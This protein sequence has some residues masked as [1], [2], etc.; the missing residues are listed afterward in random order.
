MTA[1]AETLD[2]RERA[3]ER[4]KEQARRAYLDSVAA[5]TP[6]NGQQL[7][8]L[9]DR[10]DKWGWDRI[11]EACEQEEAGDQEPPRAQEPPEPEIRPEPVTAATPEPPAAAAPAPEPPAPVQARPAAPVR[12][13]GIGDPQV[14]VPEAAPR[15]ADPALPGRPAVSAT[16]QQKPEPVV[17]AR[18]A[19]SA[20]VQRTTV[21]AVAVVAVVA[22][23]VSYA[24]MQHLAAMAGEDWRSW[25]LPLAVDGLMV[26]ASMSMLVRRRQGRRAGVL[27]WCSL[28]AGIVASLAANV[29]AAEPT[30]IGRL[31]AAWPPLALLLA[32]EL[33]MQQVREARRA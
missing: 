30:L 26:A 8:T 13:A 29:A 2:L 25:L 21:A 10:S 19:V 5:E 18:P 32:Y 28:M 23:V 7:G 3:K 4:A 15:T 17:P 31:V 24:H 9:F 16:A 12:R 11:A 33:L 27:A 6:L 22:A 20:A 1:A 14:P